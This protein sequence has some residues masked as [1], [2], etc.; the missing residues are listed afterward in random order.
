MVLVVLT[1][2]VITLVLL[3]GLVVG[4]LWTYL[5]WRKGIAFLVAYHLAVVLLLVRLGRGGFAPGEYEAGG[6]VLGMALLGYLLGSM[7]GRE[8]LALRRRRKPVMT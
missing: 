1:P 7:A 5:P 2:A 4:A 3:G 8:L 6:T